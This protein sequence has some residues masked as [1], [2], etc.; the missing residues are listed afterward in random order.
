MTLDLA[1]IARRLE[2]MVEEHTRQAAGDRFA[3]LEAAYAALRDDD[4]RSRL[5]TAKTSWLFARSD[6]EYRAMFPS[7]SIAGDF[8]IVASDGSFILPDRHSPLRFYLINIGKVILRYGSEP[9]AELS[10][11]PKLYFQEDELFVPNAVRRVPVDGTILGL[12]R[13]TDELRVA[14]DQAVR[15]GRACPALALQ[16]GTLVLWGLE[17]QQDYVVDWVLPP[18][19][20]TMRTLRDANVP[21]AAFISYPGA[22][23]FMNTLRVSVCDYP[24]RGRVVNCDDCRNR[25]ASE[26]H[27]PACDILPDVTDRFLFEKVANLQPGERT[28]TF[29]STSKILD[30]YRPDFHVH[31]FYL[32][33]GVEIA[34]VE[35]P[36]WV[37]ADRDLLEFTHAA[38]YDQCERGGGYPPAL[39]EAHE[40]AV[41]RAGERR[42]VEIMLEE[43][44]AAHGIVQRRSAKDGSKRGRFV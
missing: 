4:L 17:S 5:Q 2:A 9:G 3:T 26:G 33:T 32:H 29:A 16:D 21:V 11:E 40:V 43:S 44:L 25:I 31:F 1:G 24:A 7:R 20:E 39:Q 34:R 10:A 27:T 36:R 18:F 42:A 12:K 14:A 23:E 30:R 15:Q 8:A 28:Q 22:K 37:A 13:A 6:A 35:V 41:I 19:L 38:I